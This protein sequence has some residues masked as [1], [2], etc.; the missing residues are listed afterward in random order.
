[1]E[2]GTGRYEDNYE[3]S[4]FEYTYDKKTSLL[5]LDFGD[6]Y[7]DILNVISV[8]SSTLTLKVPEDGYTCTATR[9]K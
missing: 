2:D 6:G 8:T 1:M 3:D 9:V 5:I 4:F 7:S